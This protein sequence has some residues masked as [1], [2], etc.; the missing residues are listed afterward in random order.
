MEK[1]LVLLLG[2]KEQIIHLRRKK[3]D[4]VLRQKE[5]ARATE[6]FVILDDLQT[7]KNK[8]KPDVLSGFLYL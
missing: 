3:V 1:I 8:L 2:T 7:K 5:K 6:R 4:L